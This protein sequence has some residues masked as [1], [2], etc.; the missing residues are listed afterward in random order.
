MSRTFKDRPYR[1][2]VEDARTPR[3]YEN[4]N[5]FIALREQ[6]GEEKIVIREAVEDWYGKHDVYHVSELSYMRPLYRRWF[7]IK[8]CTIDLPMPKHGH[9]GYTSRSKMTNEQ[10]M[11]EKDCYHEAYYWPGHRGSNSKYFQ[12]LSNK[13]QRGEI[14]TQLIKAVREFDRVYDDRDI[15]Y[16]WNRTLEDVWEANGVDQYSVDVYTD[17]YYESRGWWW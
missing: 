12:R 13:A 7:A 8:P 16:P 3:K 14:R 11:A 6:I 17:S 15:T 1:I 4:H 9:K 10:L 5:H 2:R